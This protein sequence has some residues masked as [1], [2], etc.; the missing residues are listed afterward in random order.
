MYRYHIRK[1]SCE[2]AESAIKELLLKEGINVDEIVA[3]VSEPAKQTTQKDEGTS[4]DSAPLV[5]KSAPKVRHHLS[6]IFPANYSVTD[7]SGCSRGCISAHVEPRPQQVG[8]AKTSSQD[9]RRTG[10]RQ[11]RGG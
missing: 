9:E 11:R 5:S 3:P 6:R 4:Q 7:S 2:K 8:P 1:E 10:R